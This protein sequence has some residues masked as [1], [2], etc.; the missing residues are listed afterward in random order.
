[1]MHLRPYKLLIFDWD[2]TLMDSIE[3]IVDC[4]K[5]ASFEV[6]NKYEY[7]DNAFR[8]VIGLGL[9]EA[10]TQIHP[11]STA[12]QIEEMS[13]IYRQQYMHTN[14]TASK[15][16]SG[17]ENTLIQLKKQNYQLAIATGKS[18]Q[19]LDQT[20]NITGLNDY[21]SITRCASETL[22][23]PHPKMLEEILNELKLKPEEALM[24]G[25]TEYDMEM[26]KNA[27]MDRLGVSYGVHSLSRL[28]IHTP[29]GHLDDIS[30]LNR[31]LSQ[32]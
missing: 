2:G 21:F 31:F 28:M 4:L 6:L 29:I 14:T 8:D 12:Q 26:A 1:M 20:L 23:K 30:Q 19:G 18:R 10:L 32:I 25:D 7:D 16:F 11:Q 3:R 5:V 13:S 27:G 24:I 22:S 15:L 17:A 9:H